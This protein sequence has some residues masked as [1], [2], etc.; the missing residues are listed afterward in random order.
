MKKIPMETH[1]SGDAVHS[2]GCLLDRVS[3]MLFRIQD[4]YSTVEQVE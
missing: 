3:P 2:L 1:L 4:A